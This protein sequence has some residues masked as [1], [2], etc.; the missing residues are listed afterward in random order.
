LL[1]VALVAVLG[2][3]TAQAQEMT[4]DDLRARTHFEAG[5]SYFEEGAYDRARDEF[6]RAYDLSRRP[7]LLLNLATTHERLGNYQQAI[8]AI[9]EYI[10]RVPDDPN[11]ATLE[12][13]AQ[14]LERLERDRRAGVQVTTETTTTTITQASGGGGDGLMAGAIASYAVAGAGLVVMSIFGGLAL[15]EDSALRSGCGATASCTPE[16]VANADTFALVSDIGMGVAIAGAA[17]GTVLLILGLGSSGSSDQ[18]VVAP[19]VA[20]EGGGVSTRVRF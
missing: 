16:Q 12:R 1:G 10:Q 2:A 11:R 4:A 14:N 20:P 7:Q 9:R 13:R 19:W 18:A 8:N 17:T 6:Q 15:S 3:G 5:R